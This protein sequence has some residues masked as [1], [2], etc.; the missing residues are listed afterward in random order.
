MFKKV[1]AA[2]RAIE[3]ETV[4]VFWFRCALL[5][6]FLFGFFEIEIWVPFRDGYSGVD[7]IRFS[8]LASFH[9]A[10]W[11]WMLMRRIG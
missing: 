10:P 2:L 9:L 7:A 11:L 4:M 6:A 3:F 1:F 5:S 8:V